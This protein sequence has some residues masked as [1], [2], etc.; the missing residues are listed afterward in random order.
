MFSHRS[1]DHRYHARQGFT[2]IEMLVVIAIIALLASLLMS[3]IQNAREAA[4][5]TECS[6]NL[7]NISLAVENFGTTNNGRFPY[8]TGGFSVNYMPTGTI[9]NFQ[10][11]PW[12]IQLLPFLDQQI[13][14]EK[15]QSLPAIQLPELFSK[16]L[17]V[18][19]CPDDPS[20]EVNG[21]GGPTAYRDSNLSYVA[22]M[23]YYGGELGNKIH[24]IDTVTV[25]MTVFAGPDYSFN[26][27][28]SAGSGMGVRDSND[29]AV[30]R[31]TGVFWRKFGNGG[32][33]MTNQ[34]VGRG[35]GLGQTLMLSEN[36]QAQG[37][38]S[39]EIERIGFA[40]G[41][42]SL[43]CSSAQ[44]DVLP[45]G[46]ACPLDPSGMGIT[47]GGIEAALGFWSEYVLPPSSK[48]NAKI[49]AKIA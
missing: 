48:I 39:Y 5:R 43:P 26:G 44:N 14:Y 18:F 30:V 41:I 4:R 9:P 36:I 12:T 24:I 7:R 42:P 25:G 8:L 2:L 17:K 22:N 16:N 31:A 27:Y 40:V 47:G 38:G 20:N 1:H 28:A 46:P 49:N 21:D 32:F 37:W 13:I 3:A 6:N 10:N 19:S 15:L 45:S 29:S 34:Y 35:D 23:G 11:V 33:T